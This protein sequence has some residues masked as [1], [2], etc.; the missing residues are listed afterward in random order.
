MN[1]QQP[2]EVEQLRKQIK[3]LKKNEENLTNQLKIIQS[4]YLNVLDALPINIFLEDPEGHTIFANQQAC[5]INGMEREELIGKTVFD[6]FPPKIAEE[7][8]AYDLEVWNQKKLITR[9]IAANFQGIDFHMFTGKTIISIDESKE[10]FLLGF[11]LDITDRVRAEQLLRESEEKFRSLIEQA[12][13]SIFLIGPDGHFKT[14]NTT[15]CETL[16][17]TKEELQKMTVREVFTYFLERIK[18]APLHLETNAS[19]NFEDNMVTNTNENIPID[20]NVR[21][22]KLG[23]HKVFLAMCRDIRDKKRTEEQI[24]HMA[25]HDA[26]TNL[27]NRW[28]VQSYLQDK[29]PLKQEDNSILGIVLLDLDNFKVINDSLGHHAG[30]LLL[31]DVAKRLQIVTDNNDSILARFGGDEFVL[32]I[33]NLHNENEV[34]TICDAIMRIMLDPFHIYGQKFNITTSIGICLYPSDGND[35]NTLIKN[36]DLAMYRSKEQGRNC[37]S[38]YNPILKKYAM[39]RMD[40]EILMREAL[41]KNQFILHFQPKENMKTGEV[42]GMES[43][44][45]WRDHG[46]R[47][48]YPDS[49]IQIAEETGLIVPIGEWV[50]R[51]ACKNCKAWHDKGFDHLSVSVNISAKQFQKQDLGSM[52]ASILEETALPPSALELELTESI[53]MKEPE[54]AVIVLKSLK[55]LGVTISID[56]FGTGFSSLSYLKHFPIDILKIDKSFI[57]NLESDE[58]NSAIALAVISLAHSLNLKVVAEGVENKEQYNFLLEGN[59]D[60]AQGFFIHKP[61]DDQQIW[62]A[63]NGRMT[64]I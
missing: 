32:L 15:A 51:E 12:A 26:L 55:D 22:I 53:I 38:L 35:L 21:L 10:E 1:H 44:I 14:V 50:L 49:F 56:D 58:A 30:D 9:E 24:Q 33:P 42:Y 3:L 34:F 29:L 43:L 45:R 4:L 61:L 16:G 37:Y 64:V 52:V 28:F 7:N 54:E 63:L 36:A 13:D 40:L 57:M 46:N 11:G 8:R 62:N 39:E 20:I 17:Y 18:E 5:K 60:Y 41:D 19:F 31:Q 2:Q 47:I 59:C 23:N 27:P 25:Y 48:F 6:F